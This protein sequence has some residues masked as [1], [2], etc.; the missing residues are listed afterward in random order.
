LREW[1][2]NCSTSDFF[3]SIKSRWAK[4]HAGAASGTLFLINVMNEVLS[5]INCVY[6]AISQANQASLTLLRI[7]VI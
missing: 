5:T 2:W 7:N 3:Y 4:F 1:L 6:R